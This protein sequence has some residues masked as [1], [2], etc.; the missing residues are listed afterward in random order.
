MKAVLIGVAS[1]AVI[2]FLF[3]GS[4]CRMHTLEGTR[5]NHTTGEVSPAEAKLKVCAPMYKFW[6]VL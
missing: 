4:V 5:T 2:L 1:A 3:G 6:T